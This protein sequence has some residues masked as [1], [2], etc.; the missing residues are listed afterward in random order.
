MNRYLLRDMLLVYHRLH[1]ESIFLIMYICK[2]FHQNS[3]KK[4][5]LLIVRET[6][7]S[8]FISLCIPPLHERI[9]ITQFCLVNHFLDPSRNLSVYL[10]SLFAI[11]FLQK[12]SVLSKTSVIEVVDF[13][14]KNWIFCFFFTVNIVYKS[15]VGNGYRLLAN[16]RERE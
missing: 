16:K 1:T 6:N 7:I 14:K 3:G 8:T 4:C 9:H 13:E 5:Y 12:Y 15:G 11:F 10:R 2:R